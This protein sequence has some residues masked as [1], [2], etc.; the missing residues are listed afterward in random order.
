ML[1]PD[2]GRR[3]SNPCASPLPGP[4]ISLLH[5]WYTHISTRQ[6]GV[7]RSWYWNGGEGSMGPMR[8]RQLEIFNKTN[9][10]WPCY[11]DIFWAQDSSSIKSTIIP[12]TCS[13]SFHVIY[14]NVHVICFSLP[15]STL[16]SRASS[17]VK[18]SREA[19]LNHVLRI[20]L[21]VKVS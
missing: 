11:R 12:I 14:H 7:A 15:R 6:D 8:L 13:S 2:K 18:F 9:L 4:D 5:L 10:L 20:D 16:D 3:H 19:S 17:N 1:T 21:V